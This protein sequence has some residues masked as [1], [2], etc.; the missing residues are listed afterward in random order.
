[1][2]TPNRNKITYVLYIFFLLVIFLAA[3]EVWARFTYQKSYLA[4]YIQKDRVF[5]HLS[6]P[7]TKGG[8]SSEGDFDDFYVTNNRGMRGPDDYDYGKKEGLYRIAV[9][10]DSFTFG[11]G[12]KAKETYSYLVHKA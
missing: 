3:L 9:M 6:P 5:H 2:T 12:V 8:M 10:G 1:M 4:A 7:H 11:V